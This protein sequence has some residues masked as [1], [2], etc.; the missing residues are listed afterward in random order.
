VFTEVGTP[1]RDLK[2]G[3]HQGGFPM[4]VLHGGYHNGGHPREV[5]EVGFPKG[6]PKCRV[7]QGGPPRRVPQGGSPKWG[8][9]SV[10]HPLGVSNGGPQ[11]SIRER[12]PG[13]ATGV[14]RVWSEWGPPMW[15]P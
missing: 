6:G 9:P 1:K 3:F 14:S 15:V 7:C 5:P 10:G 8:P 2:S 11:G 12:P 4:G 13:G